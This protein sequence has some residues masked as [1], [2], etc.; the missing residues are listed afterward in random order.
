MEDTG[1]VEAVPSLQ[2][3][4][5]VKVEKSRRFNCGGMVKMKGCQ[6]SP[7]C[8]LAGTVVIKTERGDKKYEWMML[9]PHNRVII[10]GEYTLAGNNYCPSLYWVL[11]KSYPSGELEKVIVLH[12]SLDE[13]QGSDIIGIGLDGLGSKTGLSL[14]SSGAVLFH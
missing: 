7:V 2:T 6:V 4:E 14:M 11:C 3:F 1:V 5:W 10:P 8:H 12:Q 9:N 13:I